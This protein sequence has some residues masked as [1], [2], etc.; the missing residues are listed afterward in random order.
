MAGIL[1]VFKTQDIVRNSMTISI[2]IVAGFG[3]YNILSILVAQKRRD[4]AILRSMGYTPKNIISLFFN[5]GLI[6]GVI[7]GLIGLVVGYL[8]CLLVGQIEVA[9]GRMVTANGKMIVSYDYM[10]YVKAYTIALISSIFSSIF[11]ART[12]GSLDPMAIIRA[13][14]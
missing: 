13:G 7:G 4:I 11:P 6:L 12:A 14:S 1:S 5:Q 2:I 3:I 9:S 10:I 8:L